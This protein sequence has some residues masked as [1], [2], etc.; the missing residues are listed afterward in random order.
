MIRGDNSCDMIIAAAAASSSMYHGG[1]GAR[2]L[3]T[4]HTF[5]VAGVSCRHDGLRLRS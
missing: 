5:G 1:G 2:V 4:P 3:G